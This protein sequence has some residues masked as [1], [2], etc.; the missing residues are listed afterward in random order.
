MD[1]APLERLILNVAARGLALGGTPVAARI[2]ATL[3]EAARQPYFY[4]CFFDICQRPI[5]FGAS[6]ADWVRERAT[7]MAEGKEIWFL[8]VPT[9]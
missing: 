1:S 9:T 3:Q 8:G 7:R 2:C 6:Y 4:E 5:P